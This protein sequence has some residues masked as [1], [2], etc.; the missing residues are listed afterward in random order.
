MNW[1]N[2]TWWWCMAYFGYAEGMS[3]EEATDRS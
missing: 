2:F 3:R 1:G